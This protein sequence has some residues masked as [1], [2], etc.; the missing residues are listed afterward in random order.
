MSVGEDGV[1]VLF[2]R[3]VIFMRRYKIARQQGRCL[4]RIRLN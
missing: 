3:N 1:T 4:Q 2:K